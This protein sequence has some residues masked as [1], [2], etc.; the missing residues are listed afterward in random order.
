M[1]V[2]TTSL[3][4]V[5]NLASEAVRL[6]APPGSLMAQVMR[7]I[8]PGPRGVRSWD[9]HRGV[10]YM[11][12]ATPNVHLVQSTVSE[13]RLDAAGAVVGAST[14]EGVDRL[15]HT[16]ALCVGTFL[17]ARLI[18][19]SV[20]ETQGR[21]SEMAYDDLYQNLLGIG[22]EFVPISY[23]GEPHGGSLAYVVESVALAAEERS[24]SATPQPT[25]ALWRLPGLYAAGVCV[26]PAVVNAAVAASVEVTYAEAARQGMALADEL[27]GRASSGS[28]G[29]GRRFGVVGDLL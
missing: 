3:D 21:L 24:V 16:T 20:I 11:L 19:G 17:R 26:T 14:W 5:Y 18:T 4:T 12:E 29:S 23:T 13:L 9:L 28:G 15:A 8:V 25:A 27:N 22:F 1:V 10:K 2:V 7:D 6:S